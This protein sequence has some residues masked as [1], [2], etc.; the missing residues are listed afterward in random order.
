MQFNLNYL[1]KYFNTQNMFTVWW[2]WYKYNAFNV[3]DI[4]Y[5]EGCV[6]FE[7]TFVVV[8]NKQICRSNVSSVDFKIILPFN[9]VTIWKWPAMRNF[10]FLTIVVVFILPK[11]GRLMARSKGVKIVGPLRE[12]SF[13]LW[14]IW[15]RLTYLFHKG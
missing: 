14:T 12:N 4:L 3:F 13:W 7:A 8:D 1:R 15:R 2:R 10:L 5:F 9:S 6:L 11:C